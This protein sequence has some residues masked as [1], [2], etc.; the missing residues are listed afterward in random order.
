MTRTTREHPALDDVPTMS[1]DALWA[2]IDREVEFL[3]VEDQRRIPA[4]VAAAIREA[5]RRA[6]RSEEHVARLHHEIES[7]HLSERGL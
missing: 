4:S 2:Y 6:R 1:L 5:H 7:Y 3:S